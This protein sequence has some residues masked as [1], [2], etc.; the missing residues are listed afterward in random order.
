MQVGRG[1]DIGGRP[2]RQAL[3]DAGLNNGDSVLSAVNMI[4]EKVHGPFVNAVQC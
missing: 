4:L 1:D 3:N 2:Y